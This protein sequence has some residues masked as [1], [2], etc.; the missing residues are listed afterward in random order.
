MTAFACIANGHEQW[1]AH[2][3]APRHRHNQAYAAV[4]LS[5]CY[6]ECGSFGRFR[7]GPGD[8]L[9]HSRF[10]AH[11]DSFG[12]RGARIL[13]LV[14]PDSADRFPV[15]AGRLCD[16]DAIAKAAETNIASA[17]LYLHEQLIP[18]TGSIKDWPDKLAAD[19]LENP[20]R[21][22]GDWALDQGL[23]A[24]SLSRGF[25]KVFGI[26]P[27]AFRA[28]ARAH[29][30][31]ARIVTGSEPL[32]AIAAASGFADQAH[33]SRATRALTGKTPGHWRTTSN[34][35]KT[36]RGSTH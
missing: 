16:A 26:T 34:S 29:K 8:V 27:A 31:F 28:E 4:V 20:Q 6:E 25:R 11:L 30:A 23:A 17:L 18:L 2:A 7:V 21:H 1:S 13:N 33:L 5:G 22:L 12:T 9:I 15:G 24:E 19:L 36:A 35:F 3:R 10:E 14:I 32:A